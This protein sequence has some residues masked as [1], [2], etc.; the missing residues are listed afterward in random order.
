MNKNTDRDCRLAIPQDSEVDDDGEDK[1]D[2]DS[3]VASGATKRN[4]EKDDDDKEEQGGEEKVKTM[5]IQ[6]RSSQKPGTFWYSRIPI[7]PKKRD[8]TDN[9]ANETDQNVIDLTKDS[10]G[11]DDE[12]EENE[13]EEEDEEDEEDDESEVEY[14][15][16]GFNVNGYVCNYCDL[17]FQH[18]ECGCL[19]DRGWRVRSEEEMRELKQ[20]EMDE[21]DDY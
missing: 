10:D 16:Y 3:Q 13:E 21:P 7:H 9:D 1:M 18:D 5:L 4:K 12:E 2:S 6:Y 20:M 11:N 8:D 14:N 17:Y 15:E 19:E